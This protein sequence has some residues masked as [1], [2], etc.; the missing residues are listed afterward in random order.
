LLKLHGPTISFPASKF[1]EVVK[2][3]VFIETS[4][5]AFYKAESVGN[6]P[7]GLTGFRHRCRNTLYKARRQVFSFKSFLRERILSGRQ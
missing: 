4:D 6:A 1:Q 2:Y 3:P 7:E 5:G